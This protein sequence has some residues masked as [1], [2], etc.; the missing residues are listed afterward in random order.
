[1]YVP[2]VQFPNQADRHGPYATDG[3]SSTAKVHVPYVGV[4]TVSCSRRREPPMVQSR[5][6]KNAREQTPLIRVEEIV[7]KVAYA[8]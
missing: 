5:F 6:S 2:S 8:N 3:T 1:M 4:M 7:A